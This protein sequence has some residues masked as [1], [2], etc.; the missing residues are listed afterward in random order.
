VFN[1]DYIEQLI[2]SFMC[3]SVLSLFSDQ[4]EVLY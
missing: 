3:S 2:V 1:L 4:V